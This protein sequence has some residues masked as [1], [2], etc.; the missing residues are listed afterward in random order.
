MLTPELKENRLEICRELLQRHADEG[1]AFLDNIV[2]GDETWC[3][4]YEPESKRQLMEWHWPGSPTQKKF[5]MQKSAGKV[6]CTVFWDSKG[7]IL[8]DFLEP[9]TTVNSEQDSQLYRDTEQAQG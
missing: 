9:G 8:L 3:H 7:V 1:D 2:T 5:K 4:H 6:M